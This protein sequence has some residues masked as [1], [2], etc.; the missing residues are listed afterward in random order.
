[1]AVRVSTILL[2]DLNVSSNFLNGSF[3]I[4][5]NEKIVPSGLDYYE[6]RR[7]LLVAIRLILLILGTFG[8]VLSFVIM[9]RGSLKKVSTCFYMA[10]LALADTGE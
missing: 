10:I 8:N 7:K 2:D 5:K 9:R 6:L 3:S 1:M 4:E